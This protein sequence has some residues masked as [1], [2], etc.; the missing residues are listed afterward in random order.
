MSVLKVVKLLAAGPGVAVAYLPVGVV[1]WDADGNV[2]VDWAPDEDRTA[3]WKG[4]VER[5]REAGNLK[6]DIVEVWAE[7]LCNGQTVDLKVEEVP[8]PEGRTAAEVFEELSSQ[9]DAEWGML[10]TEVQDFL[11]GHP[12]MLGLF[13]EDAAQ[14]PNSEAK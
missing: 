7:E 5:V 8:I 4:V 11:D 6:P 12:S 9:M 2:Y 1:A 14:E 3:F 13:A 10:L